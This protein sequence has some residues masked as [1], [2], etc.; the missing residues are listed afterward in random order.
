M[1]KQT[2]IHLENYF[3][4]PWFTCPCCS[5][6]CGSV[7]NLPKKKRILAYSAYSNLNLGFG[8]KLVMRRM[9]LKNFNSLIIQA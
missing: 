4:S 1:R 9:D 7:R 6:S 3:V 2:A 8:C 5:H